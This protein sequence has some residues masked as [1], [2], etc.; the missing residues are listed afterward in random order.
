MRTFDVFVSLYAP[1]PGFFRDSESL[2]LIFVWID[3]TRALLGFSG[4]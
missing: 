1:G 2:Y 4:R 3:E